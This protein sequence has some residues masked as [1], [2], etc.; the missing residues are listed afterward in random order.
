MWAGVGHLYT[1]QKTTIYALGTHEKPQK[2]SE[3]HVDIYA[4]ELEIYL[5]LL[6]PKAGFCWVIEQPRRHFP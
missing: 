3:T 4:T 1:L 6:S 5:G 2:D